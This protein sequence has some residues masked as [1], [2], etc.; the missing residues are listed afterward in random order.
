MIKPQ[1]SENEKF[2]EGINSPEKTQNSK[3]QGYGN[4]ISKN[5]FRTILRRFSD[6]PNCQE[7]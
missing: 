3:S 6:S 2:D 5:K 7:L 4:V 1:N